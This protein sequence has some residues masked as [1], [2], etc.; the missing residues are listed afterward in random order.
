MNLHV[1]TTP[2]AIKHRSLTNFLNA[3][4]AKYDAGQTE[5]G[6][7]LTDRDC[8]REMAQ[9]IIDMWHYH[10]AETMRRE[11]LL[12]YIAELEAENMRLRTLVGGTSMDCQV[13]GNTH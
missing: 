12:A 6:G 9:E 5:H 10:A 13:E 1:D 4:S 3:A 11:K 7:L 2:D 8:H